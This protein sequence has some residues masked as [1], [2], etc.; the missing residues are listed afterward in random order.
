VIKNDETIVANFRLDEFR[1]EL[2][3]QNRPTREQE[4]YRHMIIEHRIILDR[5]ESF[6]QEVIRLKK[7]GVKTEPAFC[8]L[9]GIEGDPYEALLRDDWL[10]QGV[11]NNPCSQDTAKNAG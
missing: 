6:R 3:G 9:L 4:S 2:F 8:K 7:E 10:R 11:I 1:I 5:G